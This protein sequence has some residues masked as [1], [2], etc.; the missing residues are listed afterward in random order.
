MAEQQLIMQGGLK[1]KF[2]CVLHSSHFNAMMI[3]PRGIMFCKSTIADVISYLT[4]VS[5]MRRL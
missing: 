1:S 4:T 2:M 3:G 5:D